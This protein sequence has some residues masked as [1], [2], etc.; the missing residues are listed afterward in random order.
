M[1]ASNQTRFSKPL[2]HG[3]D[4]PSPRFSPR[5]S[6]KGR[7][8]QESRTLPDN[9]GAI[10]Y[11]SRAR[12]ALAYIALAELKK[13]DTVLIP[14]YHCPAMVEPFIWAGCN[15]KFY[16]LTADLQPCV[17]ELDT[18]LEQADAVVLVRYF[19]VQG[20][21]R[22]MT[23]L[24]HTHRCLV[25]EDLAHAGFPL[26]LIGDYGVTSFPKFYAV[27]YGAEILVHQGRDPQH[28]ERAI[29]S[30]RSNRLAWRTQR[31]GS[32]LISLFDAAIKRN[33]GKEA[34]FRYFRPE[35]LEEPINR[36]ALQQV[37]R[38]SNQE[39]IDKRRENYG[40]IHRIM[41][42]SGL[43]SPLFSRLKNET[44]PYVYPFILNDAK[45]FHAIRLAGI[46]LFR[47]EELSPTGC[48]ISNHY[49]AHLI[50]IPCHNDLSSSDIALIASTT[51]A[52]SE[53]DKDTDQ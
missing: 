36:R 12:Y 48:R 15:I 49:R 30:L 44:V 5:P 33:A 31:S 42:Q 32:R 28:V 13:G 3:G 43:G 20:S 46:P 4:Y 7:C 23:E 40:R 53:F 21:I 27:D 29:E 6:T 26:K 51:V 22:A 35:Y 2:A 25:I 39:I 16:R 1:I 38:C 11:A 14:A 19:G 41:S 37:L 47:W 24:A 10:M 50:Q 45:H 34:L 18:L 8:T 17:S 52:C 9:V